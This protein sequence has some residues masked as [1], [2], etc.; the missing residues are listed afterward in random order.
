MVKE[1]RVAE[2]PVIP[3]LSK[4]RTY[5]EKNAFYAGISEAFRRCEP[6]ISDQ[7]ARKFARA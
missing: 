4:I 7:A 2:P 6:V 5:C 3:I 1:R